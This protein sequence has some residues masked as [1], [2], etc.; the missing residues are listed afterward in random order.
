[1]LIW[2]QEA[3]QDLHVVLVEAHTNLVTLSITS[4]VATGD[5]VV[6]TAGYCFQVKD[7]DDGATSLWIASGRIDVGVGA[8]RDHEQVWGLRRDSQCAGQVG[9]SIVHARDNGASGTNSA[10]GSIIRPG[11]SLRHGA[12]IQR[13]AIRTH[14]NTM[15]QV[16]LGE[17]H[18]G[19]SDATIRAH[20]VVRDA[21]S[22]LDDQHVTSTVE[23][24]AAWTCQTA[25]D[26]GRLPS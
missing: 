17:E 19:R 22:G 3:L 9:A 14:G 1:M 25:R 11:V 6:A 5:V 15:V 13:L 20:L 21:L 2:Y 10:G 24:D 26:F 4:K 8:M 16:V 12:S 18:L 7:F 23:L